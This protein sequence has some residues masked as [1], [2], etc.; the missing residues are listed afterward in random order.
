MSNTKSHDD[1]IKELREINPNVEILSKYT[2]D[3][4]YI[5][6]R[7][8][9]CGKIHRNTPNHLLKG[10]GCPYC[11]IANRTLT[12][13]EWVNRA[14]EI[15]NHKYDYSKVNYTRGKEKI[16]IICSEHGEF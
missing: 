11:T 8:L 5:D 14:K 9:I 10:I 6:Y 1:F 13:E 15:H 7:C 3:K 16:I 4:N 2:K 12:Q